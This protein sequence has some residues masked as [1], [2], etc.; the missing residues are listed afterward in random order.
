[1][2]KGIWCL[3]TLA[4]TPLRFQSPT[5]LTQRS[6]PSFQL[7]FLLWQRRSSWSWHL[8]FLSTTGLSVGEIQKWCWLLY[9]RLQ[10]YH[11]CSRPRS[12]TRFLP[13][14]LV[15]PRTSRRQARRH[16]YE[17]LSTT[18]MAPTMRKT[19]SWS[20]NRNPSLIYSH[21]SPKGVW[22][23]HLQ[24]LFI[25]TSPHFCLLLDTTVMFADIGKNARHTFRTHGD[26]LD[27]IKLTSQI[28]AA[29]FTAWSSVRE[30]PQVFMLLETLYRAFDR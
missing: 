9:G 26:L 14:K 24:Q 15:L 17:T 7:S 18:D 20:L 22:R 5:S 27:Q 25:H 21:V 1:M 23:M 2:W 28:S 10:L 12:E 30:P 13:V 29:G 19:T 6:H 8:P 16:D 4:Y 3:I 11:L